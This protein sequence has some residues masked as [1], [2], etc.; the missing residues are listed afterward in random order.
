MEYALDIDLDHTCRIC[1]SQPDSD[2]RLFSIFS[3][4]IVDGFLVSIPEAITFC[5]ELEIVESAE[6]PGKICQACKSQM[7]NFYAF[8]RKCKRTEQILQETVSQK[9]LKDEEKAPAAKLEEPAGE[10]V[11]EKPV[12][13]EDDMMFEITELVQ[14]E[15]C[16]KM[17][18]D[19]EELK[20]HMA[21]HFEVES[22]VTS[23]NTPERDDEELHA[24]TE[25]DVQTE[26]EQAKS[27][28]FTLEQEEVVEYY[29]ELESLKDFSEECQEETAEEAEQEVSVDTGP[30]EQSEEPVDSTNNE[31]AKICKICGANIV[32]QSRFGRHMRSHEAIARVVDYFQFYNCNDCRKIFL[33][34]DEHLLHLR[35]SGHTESPSLETK[36][37]ASTSSVCG[38]CSQELVGKLDDMKLHVLSHQAVHS[39]PFRE[40]GCEY[41]SL[42]RLGVHIRHKHVEHES[43]RCQHCGMDSFDS[44]AD[45]QQ[46]LRLKC[47]AK[48]FPCHHCDKK[49]L[50]QRSLANHLK[51]TDKRFCCTE[52][53]KSFA[54]QGELKLH[55]RVHNNERPFQCT[56]CGKSYKTASLRTA[57]MDTHIE[58]KTFQCQICDKQL[59]TRT[60]YRN[61]LKR[62]SEEKKHECD[63]CS[64][65][66]YTKYHAKIHKEKVHKSNKVD[67]KTNK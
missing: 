65:K 19:E 54:Q 27:Q 17:F 58:G 52:C 14:C 8:K 63:V 39:C 55:L 24:D 61:H 25:M 15:T 10:E 31:E 44:M 29:E 30:T 28:G 12:D 35:S 36:D 34:Q 49:F 18:D 57:H 46:H 43:H 32:G 16:E 33:H 62:H 64:K 1:L 56:V 40:C 50:T 45:L 21:Q 59:K 38:I 9:R 6:M 3:S 23:A 7:L 20:L 41:A 42:A 5:V 26:M 48:K 37:D 51:T 47:T 60:C 53:G 4:A 13:E 66:F 2:Q 67:N 22:E 11:A